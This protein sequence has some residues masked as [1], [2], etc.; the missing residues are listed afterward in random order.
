MREYFA[1]FLFFSV[2]TLIITAFWGTI[3]NS[4][5]KFIFGRKRRNEFKVMFEE[6]QKGWKEVGGIHRENT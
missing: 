4:L 5:G 6:I 3:L 1:D 2:S